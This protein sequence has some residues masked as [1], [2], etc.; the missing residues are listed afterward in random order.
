VVP[1]IAAVRILTSLWKIT[2]AAAAHL[3]KNGETPWP[4]QCTAL[5]SPLGRDAQLLSGHRRERMPQ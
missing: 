3:F 5:V 1:C 4:Y 2:I